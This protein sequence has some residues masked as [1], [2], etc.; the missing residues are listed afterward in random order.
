MLEELSMEQVEEKESLVSLP[1]PPLK[2]NA[3]GFPGPMEAA[4]ELRT[5]VFKLRPVLERPG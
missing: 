2:T 3:K 4:H 5:V 1:S